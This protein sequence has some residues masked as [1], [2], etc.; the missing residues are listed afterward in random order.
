[1]SIAFQCE[2]CGKQY[3]VSN[4]LATRRARCSGC[5]AVFRVPEPIST[6]CDT[7][8]EEALLAALFEEEFGPATDDTTP[9]PACSTPVADTAVLCI[10]CGF[11][12]DKGQKIM[13]DRQ[14]P[15][16]ATQT[17]PVA[18]AVDYATKRNSV[19]RTL[20]GKHRRHTGFSLASYARGT[21]MSLTFAVVGGALW[22]LA[23]L[24]TEYSLSFLAWG[25]G[26][27]A[28]LGMALG[29]Q[30]DDGILAG[31]T[32]AGMAL[33]GCVFSKVLY[34]ILFLGTFLGMSNQDLLD[35]CA[36][37][38]AEDQLRAIGK[39]P[40]E[41]GDDDYEQQLQSSFQQVKTWD[42]EKIR[43]RIKL[44]EEADRNHLMDRLLAQQ[45]PASQDIPVDLATYTGIAQRVKLLSD[46]DVVAELKNIPAIGKTSTI[47]T[48]KKIGPEPSGSKGVT[49]VGMLLL[50]VLAFGIFGGVFLVLGIIS[51]FRIGSGYL[52][53]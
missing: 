35:H 22:T 12:T 21:L 34:F 23:S 4:D 15:E 5:Q 36:T 14:E 42:D 1:M 41:A 28:G 17:G 30:D 19:T 3:E 43:Q 50:S 26:S 11:H 25:V 20:A 24:S 47:K 2:R 44:H 27:L 39:D 6:I 18:G 45:K 46:A 31:I 49:V 8:E 32:S 48:E 10:E 40:A 7:T 38:V 33:V 16:P 29:H 51:A 53:V 9:C 52:A 37:V 13:V